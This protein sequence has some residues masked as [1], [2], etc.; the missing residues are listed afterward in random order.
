MLKSLKTVSDAITFWSNYGN[1]WE[2]LWARRFRRTRTVAVRD[3]ASGV[4]CRCRVPSYR[5]FGEVW[6]DRDYGIPNLSISPNDIVVDIGANQ[7]FYTCHAA[8]QGATVYAFEPFPDSYRQ[9]MENVATNGFS[10]RVF[11]EQ[12][13]V[14]RESGTCELLVSNQLGGGMNTIQPVFAHNAQLQV[15]STISVRVTALSSIINALAGHRVRVCKLDCEGSEFDILSSLASSDV[16]RVDAFV[17]EYHPEAYSVRNLLALLCRW[18]THQ[19]S[20][21]DDRPRRRNIIRAVHTRVLLED[22]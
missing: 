4:T 10:S 20:F 21:A 5:M 22:Q 14:G 3:R 19:V 17:I 2:I 11:A 6:H 13:A 15:A 18:K 1:P 7:G 16:D 12:C 9:L 8:W